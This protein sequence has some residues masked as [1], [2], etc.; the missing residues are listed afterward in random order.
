[1]PETESRL[2]K[3]KAQPR[4]WSQASQWN[5]CGYAY[6]LDRIEQVWRRPASWLEMGTAVHEACEKW[7]LSNRTATRE[8]AREWFIEAYVREMAETLATTPNLSYWES[9]GPYRGEADA[10]RRYK[11]GIEHVDRYIDYYTGK[12]SNEV[13]WIDPNG[14]PA[15]EL[16]FDIDLEGV[17][18]RG[19]IDAIIEHPKK[20]LIVRDTKTGR[21]PGTGAQLKVYAQAV[22][23][24]HQ[25][26]ITK[27]DYMMTNR[28]TPTRT[29]DLSLVPRSDVVDLFQ[30]MDEGVKA[31]VF[32]PKPGPGCARCSV[33]D[34]CEFREDA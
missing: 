27:G 9:S 15:I 10:S 21:D 31:E 7:E 11:V 25:V 20:G 17:R 12:G 22:Q 2:D 5:E 6:Y 14:N 4:S 29:K 34:S 8:E 18:V 33:R 19:K 28:G 16:N 24:L 30:L 32:E 3:V 1:M 23:E 26:E 13:I